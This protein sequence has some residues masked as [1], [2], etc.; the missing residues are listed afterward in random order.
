MP[1][2]H[3]PAAQQ[4]LSVNLFKTGTFVINLKWTVGGQVTPYYSIIITNNN[5]N[6]KIDN[7]NSNKIIINDSDND[8][9]IKILI[10]QVGAVERVYTNCVL[11]A[12]RS[13]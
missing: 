1:H 9:N 2:G 8:S 12:S 11:P 3:L 6:N 7:N 4:S 13:W 5:N 10:S